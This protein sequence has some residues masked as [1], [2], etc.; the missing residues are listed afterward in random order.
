[1][2]APPT[3]LLNS[4]LNEVSSITTDSTSEWGPGQERAV[5]QVL[6]DL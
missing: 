5:Q 1:M 4:I 3:G 6:A 2:R